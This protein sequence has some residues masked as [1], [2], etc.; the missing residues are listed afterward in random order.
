MSE[1]WKDIPGHEGAYQVS[2]QGR[3]RSLPR[4]V[5]RSTR[6][7]TVFSRQLPGRVLRPGVSSPL[8]HS[9]VALGRGNSQY[10]HALVM[11]AFVGPRPEGADIRHLNGNARDNRLNNLSY[12]SRHENNL[13]RL[14]HGVL[15]LTREQVERVKR[16]TRTGLPRGGQRRLAEELG[17]CES[18]ISSIKKGKAYAHVVV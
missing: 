1:V 7:G 2:D 10:V 13:D 4:T 5:T 15:K 18:L 14:D 11:Q 12:G 3:V 16:D 9:T 6:N 8:G 17:V